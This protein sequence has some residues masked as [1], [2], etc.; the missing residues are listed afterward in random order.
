MKNKI[1]LFVAVAIIDVALT[2]SAIH[3]Y[4]TFVK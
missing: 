3:I 2:V 4:N 1:K